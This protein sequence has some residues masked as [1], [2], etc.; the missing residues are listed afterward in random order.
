[1]LDQLRQIGAPDEVLQAAKA[2]SKEGHFLVF[3]EGWQA[4]RLFM[5]LATQ[6]RVIAGMGGMVYQG[7]DLGSIEPAMRLMGIKKKHWTG[8]FS[9]LKLMEQ[10]ALKELNARSK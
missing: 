5:A 4:W 10:S 8:L 9:D 3:Q 7:L 1:M 6:W 2:K